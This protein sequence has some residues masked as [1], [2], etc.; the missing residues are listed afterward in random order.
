MATIRFKC[1][2]CF[3]G[4]VAKKGST[5]TDPTKE[6]L[7]RAERIPAWYEIVES[8]LETSEG[9]FM[10]FGEAS[11]FLDLDGKELR[12]AIEVGDI[13]AQKVG[14]RWRVLRSSVE[15]Y[16]RAMASEPEEPEE[17][18]DEEASDEEASEEE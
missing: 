14:G 2:V 8:D 16:E 17:A 12:E 6:E 11:E 4:E 5:C 15:A 18:P 10:T 13:E 9:D 7:E 1:D 3:R